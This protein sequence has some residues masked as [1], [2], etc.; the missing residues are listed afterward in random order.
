M[1][2]ELNK[3]RQKLIDSYIKSLSENKIPWQRQWKENS[4]PENAINKVPY[5]GT[6]KLL[7]TF[8]MDEKSYE[9][10]RWCTFNQ[11]K[12]KGWKIKK[13]ATGIPIEYWS[14]YNKETKRTVTKEEYK[15]HIKKYPDDTENFTWMSRCYYVFNG[16]DIDG[17]PKQEH[18]Q[19]NKVINTSSFI[20]NTIK[21]LNVTYKEKGDKAY[22]NINN[23]TV[24]IP[25]SSNFSEEYYYYAT[26]LHELCHAS[27]HPTR[28][29]RNISNSFG[30]KE[31]AKEELRA[32]IS[33]SFLMQDLKLSFNENHFNNHKAYIQSW[34]TILKDDPN[35]LFRAIKDATEIETYIQDLSIEKN[36]DKKIQKDIKPLNTHKCLSERITNA[37]NIKTQNT[38]EKALTKDIN[39]QR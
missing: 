1:S 15:N 33:S 39:K 24:I 14:I 38:N 23:D 26:Q 34:L 30:T 4:I 8:I 21:N 17:I 19:I 18:E 13:G 7:L 20:N 16:N 11:A 31:Y 2:R 36:I 27:G 32:E 28:L 12:S 35:E 9:D 6:N 3:A 29:N 10:N 25:Q 22:Y 37:K 5:H